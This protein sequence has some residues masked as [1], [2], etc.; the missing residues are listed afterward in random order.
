[1]RL[2]CPFLMARLSPTPVCSGWFTAGS[3]TQLR[4]HFQA[5]RAVGSDDPA[6]TRRFDP[7]FLTLIFVRWPLWLRWP[8]QSLS[9]DLAAA[10]LVSHHAL[11]CR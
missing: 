4:P 8:Q 5:G 11:R 6:G 9:R 3:F 7:E 2:F 10:A 1:M